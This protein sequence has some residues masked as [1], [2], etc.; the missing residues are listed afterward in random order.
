M[1]LTRLTS[2][3]LALSLALAGA[4]AANAFQGPPPQGPP[5]GYGPP[6]PLPPRGWDAP[7]GGYRS[8]VERNPVE[9]GLRAAQNDRRVGAAET[10]IR[11]VQHL[12]GIVSRSE[13]PH[14]PQLQLGV[15]AHQDLPKLHETLLNNKRRALAMTLRL[16]SWTGA[17]HPTSRR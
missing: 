11:I 3:L 13:T 15:I 2:S 16:Q 10:Q 14:Q 4:S 9:V 6:P 5:P 7:P 17:C 1:K 12:G 8:D